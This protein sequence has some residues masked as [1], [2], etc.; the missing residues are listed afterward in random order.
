MRISICKAFIMMGVLFFFTIEAVQ[1]DRAK[2]DNEKVESYENEVDTVPAG[3]QILD[4][5]T[6]NP[7]GGD[8]LV[9]EE[10][11]EILTGDADDADD[12]E[13]GVVMRGDY[14][15]MTNNG[16]ILTLK[17]G[18]HA[19]DLFGYE[20][21]I[22]NNGLIQAN[23]KNAH[24]IKSLRHY[25]TIINSGIIKAT[26]ENG[27]GIHSNGN[28][29]TITNKFGG[30]IITLDGIGIFSK[31]DNNKI[32]NESGGLISTR[33]EDGHGIA[34]DGHNNKI[35]NSGM[36]E[37]FGLDSYGIK[38]YGDWNEIA[39]YGTIYGEQSGI[40][41]S[42]K[43][44]K[45]IAINYG[46]ITV[47]GEW[48]IGMDANK[49]DNM[50]LINNGII[51]AQIGMLLNPGAE[52]EGETYSGTMINNGLIS[53]EG[54]EYENWG[55][56]HAMSNS[57]SE[58]TGTISA[59]GGETAMGIIVHGRDPVTD[60][61]FNINN[62]TITNRGTIGVSGGEYANYGIW[63]ETPTGMTNTINNFGRI[64][65]SGNNAYAIKTEAGNELVNLFSSSDICGDI[66]LGEGDDILNYYVGARIK[67]RI[68]LAEGQDTANVN[69]TGRPAI[70]HTLTFHGAEN[71]NINNIIG[72]RNS[73]TVT[74]IDPSIQ[75]VKA[76]VLNSLTTGLHDVVINRLSVKPDN[77]HYWADTFH[78]Y[79]ETESDGVMF[80]Y[81][82]QYNGV[83]GGYDRTKGN[84]RFG[85][86]AGY[87]N[88]KTE[89]K[90]KSFE[91]DSDSFFGGIYGEYNLGIFRI[92]SALILG[93]ED[94][95]DE[96][97]VIDNEVGG[98]GEAGYELAKA[99]HE[100]YFFS[101]SITLSRRFE[102]S[103]RWLLEPSVT[104][105]YS[106]GRYENYNEKYTVNSNL[107]IDD[108]TIEAFNGKIQLKS[109]Y[110]LADKIKLGAYG[111]ATV[112][113]TDDEHIDGNFGDTRYRYSARNDDSIRGGQFGAYVNFAVKDNFNLNF[114]FEHSEMSGDEKRDFVTA[115]FQCKF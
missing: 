29:N 42:I 56:W 58:N 48:A 57:S 51:N 39:N 94:H 46:T 47:R 24:G 16:W 44:N 115:G 80:K 73:N 9:I 19:I 75:S 53:A 92:A 34:I 85:I 6:N 22:I 20:N 41:I 1:A 68:D 43:G 99:D 74:T 55:M 10:G 31:G 13:H 95:Q 114:N 86:M 5:D 60:E 104:G 79:R 91:T 76:P 90:Y 21:I 65:A 107:G 26:G 67:G 32:T 98:C 87:S 100:S 82:Q 105:V 63:V 93:Y 97:K 50:R 62:N 61:M 3:Q 84:I 110:R 14:N 18:S 96:R 23:G 36:I 35:T 89:G 30:E 8:T 38:A 66:D 77:S 4:G 49:A 54:G 103:E 2:P 12:S 109:I 27:F 71:I 25:N 83:M 111:G 112:T 101:P 33:G 28:D 45:S 70:A 108:R 113:Y 17:D 72:V 102:I 69:G 15:E 81:D 59:K 37:L 64:T 78:S 52:A 40:G 11:G 88:G 7:D 106:I